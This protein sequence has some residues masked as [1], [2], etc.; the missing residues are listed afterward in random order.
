MSRIRIALVGNPNSGKT[1][2]FNSFTG[3][4][5]RVGNY[6]GT[7]VE[8]QQREVERN[9][10]HAVV[11]DLPGTYSLSAY[12][13]EERVTRREIARGKPDVVVDVLNAGVLERNLYLAVQIME[14]GVPLVLGLNMMDETHK[15]GLRVDA[16]R[17]AE[18]LDV[19]VRQTVA[20]TG[21]GVDDLMY[22]AMDRAL[23][24]R[25]RE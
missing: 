4:H 21:I 11:T 6:P 13:Q 20:R 16:A 3:A 18:L 14:L 25:G 8:R 17:L 12:T 19:P 10:Q 5:R 24:C 15:K 23:E 22:A 1:T 2:L 7:T 9:G